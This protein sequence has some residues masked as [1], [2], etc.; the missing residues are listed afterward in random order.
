MPAGAGPDT[1]S[2]D[3]HVFSGNTPGM[4]Y[5]TWV[6]SKFMALGFTLEA[7]HDVPTEKVKTAFLPI[8]ESR[9][10]LLEPTSEDSPVARFLLRHGAG[11][12]HI[13]FA[14]DDI[15]AALRATVADLGPDDFAADQSVLTSSS[16]AAAGVTCAA[17]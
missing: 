3:I 4:P 8:G 12:H 2:S 14:V 7:T 5:L 16:T 10:E 11:V 6:M 15:E 13:C 17:M 9:L 1:I